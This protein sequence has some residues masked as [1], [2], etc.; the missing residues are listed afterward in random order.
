MAVAGL[1]FG[2]QAAQ[3]E[4]VRQVGDVIGMQSAEVIQKMIENSRRPATGII[5]TIIGFVTLLFG[6]TGVFVELQSALERIWKIPPK[7]DRG[8]LV[9]LKDHFVSF[10]MVLGIGFLLLVSLILS[11]ALSALTHFLG[12][13]FQGSI[14]IFGLVNATVSFAV[15][16]VLFAMIYKILPDVELEW[17]DVWLGALITSVFFAIGKYFIGLYLGKSSVSSTFGA[18][19]SL[20]VILV[21]FY[22]SAQIFLY[23]AEFT[24]V[25]AKRRGSWILTRSAE[26]K[27]KPQRKA[28]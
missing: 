26:E 18:A 23:G 5:A 3:G 16:T 8:I 22:Y 25:Y 28:S 4:I 13:S 17:R 10:T 27:L 6:A 9:L 12:E 11:A 2:Q 19:G 20:V 24:Q 1:M 7:P 14:F 15:V 21:W